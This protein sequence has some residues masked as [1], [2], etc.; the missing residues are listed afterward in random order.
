MANKPRIKSDA[1][2]TPGTQVE[3]ED[4]VA[5]IGALQRQVVSIESAMN[6]ELSA[7]KRGFEE[8]ALPL[9]AKI[10]ELFLGVKAW[11]ETNR[12][13][14]CKGTRKTVNL[15]S[16]EISWRKT[17]KKVSLKKIPDVIQALK[18][19]SLD[20]FIRTKEEVDKEAILNDADAVQ[21]VRG[22]TISQ[23]EEFIVKPFESEIEKAATTG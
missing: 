2:P 14:L 16:G 5:Q 12:S 18:S 19:L 1:V 7:I 4:M 8:E 20:R 6:D 9:N 3:A 10:E 22:I 15:T 21:G 23:K 11:A 13:D 17:P